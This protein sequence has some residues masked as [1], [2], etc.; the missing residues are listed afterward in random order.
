MFAIYVKLYY[1]HATS[2]V[3]F[4]DTDSAGFNACFLV[5]KEIAG[6][7]D[8]KQGNWDAIHVVSCNMAE[9]G[10]ASYRV[11]STVMVTVDAESEKIGQMDIAGSSAKSI[12]ETHTLPK[13]FG[14]KDCDPDIYHLSRI[15]TMIE[16][17]EDTLRN[18]V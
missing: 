15:G 12:A 9:Q 10:K 18:N 3:Y 2:S 16:K 11:I 7:K 14:T 5:K 8:V 1:D 4:N 17:N 6:E 13:D